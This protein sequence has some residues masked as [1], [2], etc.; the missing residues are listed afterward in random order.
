MSEN[1]QRHSSQHHHHKSDAAH[2]FKH[3]SLNS[4]V[5]RQ[6]LEKF[7]KAGLVILA[8]VMA[9]AVVASYFLL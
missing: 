6:R 8:I 4:I 2:E 3:R 9:I 7:V 1:S 5:F